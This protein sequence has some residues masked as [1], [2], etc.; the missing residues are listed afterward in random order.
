M[1]PQHYIY[2][3]L[4][5]MLCANEMICSCRCWESSG[6][7]NQFKVY[8][9]NV[10]KWASHRLGNYHWIRILNHL[11]PLLCLLCLLS[12]RLR[13]LI[14]RLR[15]LFHLLHLLPLIL[16][17]FFCCLLHF[18]HHLLLCCRFHSSCIHLCLYRCFI[19]SLQTNF[20][21]RFLTQ[22]MSKSSNVLQL[23]PKS[24]FDIFPV[25]SHPSLI[26]HQS[27]ET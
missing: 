7:W 19:G 22:I 6:R 18:L 15:L 2:F 24:L 8:R 1:M 21:V 12:F 25:C 17:V 16:I 13:P 11:L 14:H 3:S 27:L 23:F 4:Y 9:R 20:T 26:R 10:L 5:L